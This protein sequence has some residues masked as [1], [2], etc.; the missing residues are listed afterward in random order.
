MAGELEG[1]MWQRAWALL[2]QVERFQVH[3]AGLAV[4]S[5]ELSTGEQSWGPPINVV[6]VPEGLL[7]LAAVPG[8]APESIEALIE[9]GDLILRGRRSLPKPPDGKLR[10][11]EIP[12]GPF[13][14]RLRL[15][16]GAFTLEDPH[17]D[18][19]RGL[20]SLRLRRLP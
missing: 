18:M 16:R 12:C 7:I 1:W 19:D 5:A 3:L 20:L 17:L 10:L 15:P 2:G 14:R 11:L 4:S 8:V 6:E 9:Q 13:E